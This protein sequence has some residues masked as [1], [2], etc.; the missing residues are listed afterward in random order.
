MGIL[1]GKKS[2]NVKE[3]LEQE[4]IRKR[5]NEYLQNKINLRAVLEQG[6]DRI[7]DDESRKK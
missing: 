1:N 7:D 3:Y 5:H 6:I 4:M 2:I